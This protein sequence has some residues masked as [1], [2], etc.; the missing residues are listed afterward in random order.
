MKG[1]VLNR[2]SPVATL[3]RDFLKQPG[4]FYEQ[5]SSQNPHR[6]YHGFDLGQ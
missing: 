1:G 6:Q 3:R 5:A 2:R 4:G